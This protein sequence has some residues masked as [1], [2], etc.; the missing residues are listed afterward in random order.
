[1]EVNVQGTN[2]D[3]TPE[4]TAYLDEKLEE[5]F[6]ALGSVDRDPI[7]VDVEL[8]DTTRRHPHELDDQR[9]Y[10]AEATVSVP[11][12]VL[13]AVG[14]EDDLFQSIVSMKQ[15]L[16]RELREWRA[17]VTDDRRQGAREAKHMADEDLAENP[18]ADEATRTEERY[19]EEID[20]YAEEENQPDERS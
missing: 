15:I 2:L 7:L 18:P 20:E 10:R 16:Q 6:R 4:I 19:T 8:E 3:L 11:G 5:T 17:R 9:R 14:S 1:M 13:R 12:R